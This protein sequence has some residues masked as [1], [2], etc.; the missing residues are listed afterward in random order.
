M[1]HVSSY[2]DKAE[3]AT[4]KFAW[5]P[6]T[7]TISGKRIWLKTYVRLDIFFDDM[8]IPPRKDRSWVLIYSKN[9][10]LLYQITKDH[11]CLALK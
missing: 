4:E 5:W 9:E 1:K 11:S 2:F 6:V 8:G 7:T 3:T 10:Y